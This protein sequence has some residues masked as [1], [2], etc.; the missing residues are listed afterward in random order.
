VPSRRR[1]D[2]SARTDDRYG[3]AGSHGPVQH[4]DLVRRRQDVGKHHRGFVGYRLRQPIGRQIRERQSRVLALDAIDE[5]AQDPPAAATALTVV[6]FAA[7]PAH[8]ACRD[9]RREHTISL[10][11]TGD[12]IANVDNCAYGLMA[13]NSAGLD[14]RNIA[15]K[16]EAVVDWPIAF[17]GHAGV[18]PRSERRRKL[19]VRR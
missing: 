13:Q 3:V 18:E 7:V 1:P 8:A 6:T 2:R 4:A 17:G 10:D 9:A 15:L 12:A 19:V 5:M 14:R 11:Q 16:D